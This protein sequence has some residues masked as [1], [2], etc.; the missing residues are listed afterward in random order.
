LLLAP[1]AACALAL[2]G[3]APASPASAATWTL[4]DVQQRICVSPQSGH[5]G[6]YVLAPVVGTWSTT[7]TTGVRDLPPGSSSAGGSTLPPGSNDG[8]WVNGFVQL[9][10]APAPAGEYTSEVWAFD[11]TETQTVPVQITFRDGC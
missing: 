5:P 1:V 8:S 11:G 6:T 7:I 9:S 10:I 2:T 4:Q 3:A